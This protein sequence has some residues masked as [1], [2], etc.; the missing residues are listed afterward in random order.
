VK[1]GIGNVCHMQRCFVDLGPVSVDSK[2]QEAPGVLKG[3]KKL[4][5]EAETPRGSEPGFF[6]F[7]FFCQLEG[8]HR[9]Q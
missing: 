9:D 7:L 5:K 1:A 8:F 4:A 3:P 6:Y 2:Q